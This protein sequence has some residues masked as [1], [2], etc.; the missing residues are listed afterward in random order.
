MRIESGLRIYA[1]MPCVAVAGGDGHSGVGAMVDDEGQRVG[2]GAT[3][4]I[5][6]V[7]CINASGSIGGAV[8]R[9]VVADSFGIAVVAAVV[10]SQVEG[11]DAVAANRIEN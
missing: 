6:I 3:V 8:P 1:I 2:A 4:G 11:D 5:G 10:N 7:E 9:V